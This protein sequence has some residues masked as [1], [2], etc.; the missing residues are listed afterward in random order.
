[1]VMSVSRPRLSADPSSEKVRP[2]A[3]SL[4]VGQSQLRVVSFGDIRCPDRHRTA[5]L[6][7]TR[8]DP[9]RASR[10]V[11]KTPADVIVVDGSLPPKRLA[12]ILGKMTN[13][14]VDNQGRPAVLL[15]APSGRRRPLP[16]PL[17]A[18]MDEVIGTDLDEREL[19]NQIQAA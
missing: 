12:E 6:G 16:E 3:H 15:L 4:N 5:D 11:G 2:A 13:L 8:F 19:L 17:A 10:P 9:E 14:P 18:M 7:W 1:M